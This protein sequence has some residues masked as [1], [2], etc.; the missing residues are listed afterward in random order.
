MSSPA[1]LVRIYLGEHDHG[2]GSHRPLWEEIL[3]L[4]RDEGAAG[5]TMIR[6]LAGFGEHHHLHFARVADLV[7]DLPVIV[8]WIDSA[9]SV[10]RLL[11]LV[12]QRIPGGL[13]TVEDV[14]IV[15]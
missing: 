12:R 15:S 6:G 10:D 9:E 1:K 8:E 3:T 14:T 5:A 13:V 4:L 7:P 11:P 2:L